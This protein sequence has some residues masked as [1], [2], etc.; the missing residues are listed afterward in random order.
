MLRKVK[1]KDRFDRMRMPGDDQGK[2]SNFPAMIFPVPVGGIRCLSGISQSRSGTRRPCRFSRSVAHAREQSGTSLTALLIEFLL[3]KIILMAEGN[4]FDG[5]RRNFECVIISNASLI[6][7]I[8]NYEVI[9]EKGRMAEMASFIHL[10]RRTIVV[11]SGLGSKRDRP[12][13]SGTRCLSD[14][15]TRHLPARARNRDLYRPRT[16][17]SPSTRRIP[18]CD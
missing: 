11:R 8:N 4:E 6:F 16:K 15:R 18:F 2:N 14:I 12:G 13:R 10:G 9:W 17:M 1:I 7:H 5:Q 3:I